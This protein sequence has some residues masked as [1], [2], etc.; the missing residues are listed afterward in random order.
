MFLTYPV[1]KGALSSPDT[2]WH[3]ACQGKGKIAVC[4]IFMDR[5][6]N[7]WTGE[8]HEAR[9]NEFPFAFNEKTKATGHCFIL[10]CSRWKIRESTGAEIF[11]LHSY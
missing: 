4:R 2:T 9:D 10:Y 8:Y 7:T 5:A 1:G 11:H 3:C 6:D